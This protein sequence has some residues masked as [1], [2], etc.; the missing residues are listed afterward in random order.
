MCLSI[1]GLAMLI[2]GIIALAKGEVAFTKTKKVTGGRARIIGVVMLLPLPALLAF[3]F[4]YGVVLAASGTTEIDTS[5]PLLIVIEIV[6]VLGCG[7]LA[8]ILGF[9]WAE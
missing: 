2:G 4:I 7:L 3:G 5:D 9:V 1:I 8:V 6:P